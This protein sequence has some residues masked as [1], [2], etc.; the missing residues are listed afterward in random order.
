MQLIVRISLEELIK[1]K[2]DLDLVGKVEHSTGLQMVNCLL[3]AGWLWTKQATHQRNLRIR[4][5]YN[6][7]EAEAIYFRQENSIDSNKTSQ[8]IIQ[9]REKMI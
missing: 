1:G 8:L 9:C 4:F 5:H 2:W 6:T 3:A 7:Y